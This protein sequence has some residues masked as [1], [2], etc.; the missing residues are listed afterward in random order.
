M[1]KKIC[2]AIKNMQ[3]L[4]IDYN[5]TERIIEPHAYGLNKKNHEMLRAFQVSGFSKSDKPSS[6]K[7]FK[8]EHIDNIIQMSESFEVRE[9]YNPNGDSQIPN[10]K[11]MI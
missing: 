3:M 9:D 6:W 10:I 2:F 4:K 8:C 7:L 11:C 1:E 5:G